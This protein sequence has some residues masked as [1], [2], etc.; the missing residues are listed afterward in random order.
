[1]PTLTIKEKNGSVTRTTTSATQLF[2][3]DLT[4]HL[5][6]NATGYEVYE[7]ESRDAAGNLTYRW[8][9]SEPP[10]K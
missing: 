1:M 3:G 10:A 4:S 7:L 2:R 8:H 5:W 6:S 9:R